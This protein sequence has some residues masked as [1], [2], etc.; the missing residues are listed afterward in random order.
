MKCPGCG[1]RELEPDGDGLLRCI[2]CGEILDGGPEWGS[3][4]AVPAEA[5]GGEAVDQVTRIGRGQSTCLGIGGDPI[6]G[7]PFIDVLEAF[8]QDPA[9][10]AMVMIGEIGGSAEERAADFVREHISKPVVGFIAGR[11]APPGKRMGHAGAIIAGGKGT[12]AAKMEALRKAGIA[13]AENP[14][15]LG[16][17]L[18]ELL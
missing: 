10:K 3:F 14:A 8:E 17:T 4:T 15:K 7:T 18:A 11:T 16:E 12:A 1:G 9:T 13:V 5:A 6:I 2:G